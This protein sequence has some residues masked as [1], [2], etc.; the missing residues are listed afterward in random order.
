MGNVNGRD[1]CGRPE[2]VGGARFSFCFSRR[3][4]FGDRA[5]WR[6]SILLGLLLLG[7]FL[8]VASS[9]KRYCVRR[10]AVV[11]IPAPSMRPAK[12]ASGYVEAGLASDTLFYAKPPRKLAGRNVG[13]YVPREQLGGFLAFSP[14][15]I[16]SIGT[17]FEYGLGVGAVPIS[18]GLI[19]PPKQ[20]VGGGGLH[21]SLH[22]KVHP[23]V[24]LDWTSD[25]WGYEI[26]SRV[27]YKQSDDCENE[28]YDETWSEKIMA[29][30][31]IIARTQVSVG[32]DFGH[33]HLTVGAGLRN[34][35]Y[36]KD[37][38]VETHTSSSDINAALSD[39]AYPYVH[40]GWE[41]HFN[42]WAHATVGIY[43]PLNFDPVIYAPIVGISFRFTQQ[44]PYFGKG[45]PPLPQMQHPPAA[46]YN[47]PP[48]PPPPPL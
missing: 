13:L 47:P 37:A 16:V 29:T 27:A 45:G 31:L 38:T 1:F 2:A 46:P 19:P 48:P 11:P 17:S 10:A 28:Q 39:A 34:H 24:T 5:F 44:V 4:F 9:Q 41:F 35:P 20:G 23:M 3:R 21:F 8:S 32:L 18:E 30:R 22:F 26:P 43:Q 40:A 12:Q 36:N 7:A 42:E 25:I 14:H 33:S 6:K 15:P